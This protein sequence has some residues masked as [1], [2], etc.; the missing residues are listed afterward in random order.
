MT[1]AQ[2]SSQSWRLLRPS[3]LKGHVGHSV[4]PA[5]VFLRSDRRNAGFQR[6]EDISGQK[7]YQPHD[8]YYTGSPYKLEIA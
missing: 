8:Y 3:S 6:G 2:F 1:A 7:Q 5:M 4:T